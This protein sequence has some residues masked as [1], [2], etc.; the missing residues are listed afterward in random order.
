MSYPSITHSD[1]QEF[2]CWLCLLV[3]PCPS[4]LKLEPSSA[5]EAEFCQACCVKILPVLKAGLKAN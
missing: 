3:T 4:T 2:T 1:M 5:T